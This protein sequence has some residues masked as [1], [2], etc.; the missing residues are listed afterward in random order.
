MNFDNL[1][2]LVKSS[3]E[4]TEQGIKMYAP[5]KSD[6]FV[7]PFTEKATTSAPFLYQ[8][9]TGDF[10]F[11]AKVS[12]DF[13]ATYDACV[14][15][16][17]D[18]EKLWA[19][20][21]FEYTDLNTHAIVSVMTNQKSDDANNVPIDNNEVWLQLARKD[22]VFAIHYSTDGQTFKMARLTYLPMQKTIKVGLV[23]QSPTGNGG[24]YYFENIS[25]DYISL[26]NIR[27][28]NI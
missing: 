24:M 8:E 16:A 14:L 10:V 13:I 12:H 6:Y 1:Q 3:Y 28:G 4:R 22:N 19:K 25:L 5:A 11:K 15:L 27:D 17:L 2:W 20:A 23:A 7:D 18:N 21:C 9:V 26:E